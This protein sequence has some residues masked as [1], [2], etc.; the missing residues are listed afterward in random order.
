MTEASE[1]PQRDVHLGTRIV[2]FPSEELQKMQDSNHFLGD[3]DM[4]HRELHDKGYL[5]I[6]NFHDRQDVIG[7][8][9][10][11]LQHIRKCGVSLQA[12]GW[13]DGVMRKT[14]GIDNV[15]FMEGRNDI[16]HSEELKRVFEGERPYK[17]FRE[18]LGCNARTFDFKWLRAVPRDTFTGVHVDNVYMGRGTKHLYT[19]WTPIGDIPAEMGVVAVCEGSH[20][21]PGFQILQDT[22]GSLDV[23]TSRL[24]GTGWF[25]TDPFEITRR[26]GG[27]WKVFDFKAGDVLIFGMRTVHMSTTNKTEFLRLSCDTRWQSADK[28]ADPRYIGNF[29]NPDPRFGLYGEE[30]KCEEEETTMDELRIKWG[31]D[32]KPPVTI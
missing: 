4:L 18:F 19:L 21:L 28:P 16:T 1:E 27:K 22:Y 20:R 5:L 17:F 11:V 14:C 29:K 8:K 7:A 9:L 30:I 6:R 24:K 31:F 13:R 2:R 32:E 15:P 26:F 12:D 3:P 23:E 10:A 25:T